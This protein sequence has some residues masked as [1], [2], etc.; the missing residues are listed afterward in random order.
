MK[1]DLI[2]APALLERSF[3]KV[4]SDASCPDLEFYKI[5]QARWVTSHTV[6]R[7]EQQ[8][9]TLAL[10]TLPLGFW[11]CIKSFSLP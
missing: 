4:K 5:S 1:A 7:A 10:N 11:D 8:K 2:F 6:L 3:G 9:M